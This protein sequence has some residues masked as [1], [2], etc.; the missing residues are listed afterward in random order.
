MSNYLTPCFDVAERHNV[1]IDNSLKEQEV[2]VGHFQRRRRVQCTFFVVIFVAFAAGL[3]S[4]VVYTQWTPLVVI[5]C[6]FFSFWVIWIP[7]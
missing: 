6:A 7:W 2:V 1:M 5:V 4:G 3:V